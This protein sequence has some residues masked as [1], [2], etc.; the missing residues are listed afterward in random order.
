MINYIFKRLLGIAPLL[1]GITLIGFFVIHLAPGK[2]TSLEQSLNPRISAQARARLEKLY[3]LDKPLHIQYFN[4]IKQLMRFDFGRSFYD[5]RPVTEKII[6]RLPV[7]LTINVLSLLLI[8][9][10]AIPLGVK[11]AVKAGGVFD[12][13]STVILFLFFAAPTFWLA[14]LLMQLFCINLGWLPISGIKSLDYEYF[15]LWH[16]FWDISRHL[17]L[18]V[19]V[20]AVSG[21]AGLSRYMRSSMIEALNQPY[22]YA[23]RAKGLSQRQV[24]YRHALRNALLPIVTIL[25]LSLPGLIGG[26]VIFES[27]FAIPG[28]G[29]LFYEAVMSRDYPLIMAELVLGAVLTMFGNL[30]ADISY[31]Y[32]DPRI[33]Y[34]K[35]NSK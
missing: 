12:N 1:L 11:S 24:I 26:S 27:I 35:I 16:K 32:V 33:R 13:F 19:F 10:I 29:R 23:A 21:L 28:I 30:I 15:S 31:A 4:W 14:L 8:L 5:G 17:I 20:S 3:G 22:I 6:E 18:P 9:A 7:T 34:N 25:G 2:P